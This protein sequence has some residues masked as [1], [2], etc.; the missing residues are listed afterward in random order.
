MKVLKRDRLVFRRR[1][2]DRERARQ[3]LVTET[4]EREARLARGGQRVRERLA[5]ET[6]YEMGGEACETSCGG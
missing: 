1:L 3:R 5:T 4:E 2:R 6:A